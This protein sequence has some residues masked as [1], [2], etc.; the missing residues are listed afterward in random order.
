MKKMFLA[1]TLVILTLFISFAQ[2]DQKRQLVKVVEYNVVNR[3][4]EIDHITTFN[5]EGLKMEEV[6]FFADG[7]VK[8]KTT[9]EYNKQKQCV[10]S[11]RYDQKGKI[12]KIVSWEYNSDG[13]VIIESTQYPERRFR[14]DK[15][16]EYV[17]Q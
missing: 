2:P 13:K 16:F 3:A 12:D 14:T 15:V 8:T 1:G 17:Y 7:A 5:T 4:K 9:Y 10:K 11:I 6:E